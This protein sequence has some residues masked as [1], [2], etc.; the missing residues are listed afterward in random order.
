MGKSFDRILKKGGA[1]QFVES[2]FAD[3]AVGLDSVVEPWRAHTL[4]A[5]TE[6]FCGCQE[7]GNAIESKDEINVLHRVVE[8]REVEGVPRWRKPSASAKFCS[9]AT[10]GSPARRSS[11]EDVYS[12]RFKITETE[13]VLRGYTPETPFLSEIKAAKYLTSED[14]A[15]QVI[16][17]ELDL[18]F[19]NRGITYQVGDSIGIYCPNDI[20][21]VEALLERLNISGDLQIQF[22]GDSKKQLPHIHTPCSILDAFLFCV[23]LEA[24]PQK[25]FLRILAEYCI[26]EADRQKLY[27]LCGKSK[28]C[29]QRYDEMVKQRP[30]LLQLLTWYP[31]CYPDLM[32]LLESLPSLSPRYYS[33]SSSPALYPTAMHI[34]LTI[35]RYE[36]SGVQRKG[37]CSSWLYDLCVHE[38]LLTPRSILGPACNRID[39]AARRDSHRIAVPVFIRKGKEFTLPSDSSKPIIMIGPGTGVSPFRAFVQHRSVQFKALKNGGACVGWWRGFELEL[40][41]KDDDASEAETPRCGKAMLFFGCR[42]RTMDYLYGAEFEEL[43]LDRALDEFCVAFSREVEGHKVYVQDLLRQRAQEVY[44]LICVQNGYVFVCGDV[45]GMAKDVQ[46]VFAEIIRDKS[47]VSDEEAKKVVFKMIQ[48][49]RY[50][51]DIWN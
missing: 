6:K 27:D 9:S 33:I 10:V 3:E 5:L 34:A 50:V 42:K 39:G 21:V 13:I 29:R 45:S 2:A 47:N 49:K 4:K 23:D 44:D 22:E 8:P 30:S 36:S 35:V 32:H 11:G 20:H 25:A 48:D 7:A 46:N 28:D 17:I 26:D 14:S 1:K 51:Q 18:P 19:E 37:L 12:S 16:H 31:S 43:E 41:V 24:I 38:K 40:D 15:K